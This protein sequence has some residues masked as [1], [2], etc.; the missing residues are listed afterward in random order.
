M[1]EKKQR[2]T[3]SPNLNPLE[4]SYPWSDA[5]SLF[6]SFTLSQNSFWIES[7]IEEDMVQLPQV[8]INKAASYKMCSS[9][10]EQ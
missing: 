8:P 7:R 10:L 6:E 3:I 9:A 2:P 4:V 5:G 1:I